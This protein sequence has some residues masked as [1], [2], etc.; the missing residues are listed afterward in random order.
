MIPTRRTLQLASL[1]LVLILIGRG[2]AWSTLAAWFLLAAVLAAFLI[3]GV[4][5]GRRPR[6][7][8]HRQAPEQLHVDQTHTIGWVIENRS[9][10]AVTIE[11]RDQVPP[12]WRTEPHRM[13]AR[14]AAGS[15][16]RL[17]Y[18]LTPIERGDAALGDVVYR[19]RGALGLAWRQKQR[20][21][22]QPVRVLPQLANWKA[23]ELAERRA[24]VRQAGSHRYRWRGAGTVFES[25]REY[26]P[27]D[28]IRWLDWKA[29]ARAQRP[30]SRNFETERHQ[31][32][33]L[34]VDASRMMTTYCG[35]R[36]K[37][38]A[39][40]EAAVL[41]AR[42]ALNQGDAL[43][44]IAFS[45]KVDCYLHPR[46]DRQQLMAVMDALY[47][48]QP[49]LVEPDFETA[50]TMAAQRNRRRSLIILFTDVTVIEAAE[51]MMTYV[52]ALIPRHLPLVVTI[53]DETVE[54]WELTEP[55]DADDFYQVGI[56]NGLMHERAELLERLRRSGA[57]VLDSPADQVATASI[58]RYLELKRR[59]RL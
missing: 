45:D 51:R 5:A 12:R 59:L 8:L 24:M 26:S 18:A 41:T 36:T 40:L 56:A 34:L 37:F 46:R 38:D 10:F 55:R 54:A 28:D 7:E 35:E 27:E 19:V 43:G 31:Q 58:E 39:V 14:V 16:V 21:A 57:H 33:V 52:R 50:L 53:R 47:D 17:L 44:L 42:T 49:R 4:L 3:D 25:L 29:T 23:A 9:P 1:A 2:A 32:V 15:R 13:Q 22:R 20:A 48:R 6:L 11:L 30:I